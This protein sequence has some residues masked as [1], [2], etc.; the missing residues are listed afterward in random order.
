MFVITYILVFILG[1]LSTLNDFSQGDSSV[2]EELYANPFKYLVLRGSN[3][4][5][6]VNRKSWKFFL[7]NNQENLINPK[8]IYRSVKDRPKLFSQLKRHDNNFNFKR[9]QQNS[10]G[11]NSKIKERATLGEADKYIGGLFNKNS[12]P[13]EYSKRTLLITVDAKPLKQNFTNFDKE[14]RKFNFKHNKK[15]TPNFYRRLKEKSKQLTNKQDKANTVHQLKKDLNQSRKKRLLSLVKSSKKRNVGQQFGNF[16]SS[17]RS[18]RFSS[19]SDCES[20]GLFHL[21]PSPSPKFKSNEKLLFNPSLYQKCLLL[22]KINR[23]ELS[24]KNE[25]D[26]S[27]FMND[28]SAWGSFFRV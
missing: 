8:R 3:Y 16:S 28:A 21:P 23:V 17:I 18:K 4:Y 15:G 1:G 12:P 10:A 14:K 2:T 24:L 6:R 5:P 26:T 20:L 19:D 11:K 13:L 7:P 22:R 25:D 9:K 27:K